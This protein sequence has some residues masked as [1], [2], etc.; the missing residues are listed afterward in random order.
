MLNLKSISAYVPTDLRSVLSGILFVFGILYRDNTVQCLL[1]T[2]LCGRKVFALLSHRRVHGLMHPFGDFTP[3]GVTP[4]HRSPLTVC[5]LP[6]LSMSALQLKCI[7]DQLS[8]CSCAMPPSLRNY[9]QPLQLPLINQSITPLTPCRIS[10]PASNINSLRCE[11][12]LNPNL[13]FTGG[14]FMTRMDASR[15][16]AMAGHYCRNWNT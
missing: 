6:P 16:T 7:C 3:M 13:Q 12:A 5:A 10:P 9:D 14:Q 8:L 4:S 11:G 1:P 2:G 15:A